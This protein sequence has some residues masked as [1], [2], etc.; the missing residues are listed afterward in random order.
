M[1]HVN[2]AVFVNTKDVLCTPTDEEE[3]PMKTILLLRSSKAN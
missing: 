2:F 1:L 3:A